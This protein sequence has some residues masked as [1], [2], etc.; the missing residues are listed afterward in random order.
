MNL[1][2]AIALV[3]ISLLVP[4]I[5]RTHSSAHADSR[6]LRGEQ[7]GTITAKPVLV[8][9]FTSEGCSSCPPADKLLAQID[10]HQPV[11]GAEAIILEEHVDYWDDQGWRDP[12][13]SKAAT[14]RQE[15]YAKI[16]HAEVYTP[17]M[18]VDGRVELLGSDE[19]AARRAIQIATGA[20]KTELD[21]SWVGATAT[22]GGPKI[23]RVR[24]KKLSDAS[25]SDGQNAE[26][27]LAITESHLHSDVRRG[28]NAGRGLQH[29][30]VLR[31]LT[32]LGRASGSG[33]YSFD[34]Q[35]GVKLS[36][37]WI[38]ENTRVIVFV[39][40]TRSRRIYAATSTTY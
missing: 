4:S 27:F 13:A 38:R 37:D 28:E 3:T 10:E 21:L 5:A 1:R 8:E 2:P 25:A 6:D 16:L 39:Q 14:Q 23:L 33:E 35:T 22:I 7:A 11:S 32:S 31:K 20:P 15:D 12:F 26:V 24:A 9:L 18:I 17:Q 36:P 34:L 29:E 30:G 40:D 19:H